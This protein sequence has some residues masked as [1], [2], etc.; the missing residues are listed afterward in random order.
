MTVKLRSD[1][2]AKVADLYA[3]LWQEVAQLHVEW[4]FYRQVFVRQ[5]EW[6]ILNETAPSWFRTVQNI[7]IRDMLRSCGC[8]SDPSKT[9]KKENLSLPALVECVQHHKP[10]SDLP[11][12]IAA[13]KATCATARH[14]RNR[15]I[16]HYDLDTRG[17]VDLTSLQPISRSDIQAALD[18]MA[19]LLNTIAIHFGSHATN[20]ADVVTGP[21][22]DDLM[23]FL[24]AGHNALRPRQDPI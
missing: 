15:N 14:H 20:F 11:S 2:P 23:R 6:D 19:S 8:L 7:W 12:K 22:G 13:V 3:R 9:G 17:V 10:H 16:A 18:A 1:A 5:Q 21:D 4:R 24:R